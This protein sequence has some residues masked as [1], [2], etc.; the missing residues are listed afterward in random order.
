M[1]EVSAFGTRVVIAA[2][3]TFPQGVEITQFADDADPVGAE[4]V[5]IKDK[6]V[7]LNG[8]LITWSTPAPV[9]LTIGVIP[10]SDDAKNLTTLA[11]NNRASKG[12]RPVRDVI[13]ATVIFPDGTTQTYKNG[14]ITDAPLSDGAQQSGRLRTPVFT[15]A[16]EGVQ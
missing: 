15:F 8:D 9:G 7:G 10:G 5:P 11:R 13:Q 12:R 6:A 3:I 2:S 1:Q 14:V 16:F 4:P